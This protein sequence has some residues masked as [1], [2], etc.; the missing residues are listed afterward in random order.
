MLA[1]DGQQP[2][3]VT[4]SLRRVERGFGRA[5]DARSGVMTARERYRVDRPAHD[6]TDDAMPADRTV[7]TYDGAA[8]I[9]ASSSGG[10]ADVFGAVRPEQHPYSAFDRSLYTA[11]ET[12]PLSRPRGQ[13]VE[14]TFD[15]PTE[16][17]T[18]SLSF[19]TV[20]GTAVRKVR[21]A[22]DERSVVA[23]VRAD[24][25]VSDL[26]LDD[27]SASRL[28]VTVLDAGSDTGQVRLA[29][30]RIAGHDITRSLVLPGTGVLGD[31]GAR[32]ERAPT[33]SLFGRGRRRIRHVRPPP[34]RDVRDERVRTRHQ[35]ERDR[36]L[37]HRRA[38]RR[39]PRPRAGRA[40]R[41]AGGRPGAGRRHLHVRRGPCGHRGRSRGRAAP[42]PAGPLPRETPTPSL[43]LT[44]GPRRVVSK[45]EVSATTGHPG[46]LPLSL[47]V[48]G[49]P[50]T[51]GPQV[52]ATTGP[53][54]GEMRP[55]R[56]RQ[57]RVT[58]AGTAGPDG[59]GISE[60]DV[61]GIEDLRYQPDLD[62]PTGA[63]CGF[64]P[65][66]EVAGQAVPTRLTGT[67]R[68]VR[69]GAELAVVP[70]G[71]QGVSL[72]PGTHRI[73]VTNP[74]GF[75][76]TS[77]SLVPPTPT[78]TSSAQPEQP[79]VV[80]WSA[81]ERRVEVSAES[82][83]ALVVGETYNRG[84]RASVSGVELA[85]VVVDGW[86]Q[87]FVL[88]A[89]TTGVAELHYAPQTGLQ[90][91][92]VGGLV[93]AGVLV[94]LAILL[95]LAQARRGRRHGRAP[96]SDPLA[97]AGGRPLG[98]VA[99]L[100][101]VLALAVVS[102]PLAVGGVLGRLTRERDVRHVAAACTGALV[103]AAVIA[104]WGS[105]VAPPVGSDVLAALVVGLVCGRVLTS[106]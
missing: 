82:A 36:H 28:R 80:S 58:A 18:V 75:A 15:Q 16:V 4:D 77:L 61:T 59:V 45:V 41:A 19:D 47:V 101:V 104:L 38:C 53:R 73:R 20:G 27:D 46:Q 3:V 21:V 74:A 17:D 64:G 25:T 78:A 95:L 48:D 43:Q 29:D 33:T 93:M 67:L 85:P 72:L 91:A 99:Q 30:V 98:R 62:G 42:R 14:V 31:R 39:H 105:S 76:M 37:A 55:V 71:N 1:T 7:A 13:W 44:W 35:R 106:R 51:G 49:G 84:W 92:L 8:S 90:I 5:Y 34:A 56:T 22:T 10:Y 96:D 2:D 63:A 103:V 83:S 9:V 89:G 23:A 87:G 40:L 66:V 65:T 12:A 94:V 52:V 100:V 68:D 79:R 57:L 102:L 50:G 26:E 86:R 60:L 88:P 54:A 24:G 11:W 69:S 32:L 70:C 97:E 6:Y 81:T